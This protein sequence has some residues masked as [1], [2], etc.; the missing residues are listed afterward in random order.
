[1]QS[2]IRVTKD[3]ELGHGSKNQRGYGLFSVIS[4]QRLFGSRRETVLHESDHETRQRQAIMW[5]GKTPHALLI[6]RLANQG[7]AL[8]Q[9][10]G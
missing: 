3:G 7:S 9:Q 6:K 5:L 1:V 4:A 10:K 2:W 8:F